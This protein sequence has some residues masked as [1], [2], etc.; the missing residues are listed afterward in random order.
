MLG[1]GIVPPVG[2]GYPFGG[3]SLL[4]SWG[5]SFNSQRSWA[6][7]F[8]AL[9]RSND[10]IRFSTSSSALALFHKTHRA[11]CR[12]FNGFISSEQLSPS[13]PPHG[14]GE[15]GG[16]CSL[17]FFDLSGFLQL[18]LQKKAS[19]SFLSPLA[20][21]LCSSHKKHPHEPQGMSTQSG[22]LFLLFRGRQ[23]VWPFP[24]TYC[25]TIFKA[26]PLAD[27]FFVFRIHVPLRKRSARS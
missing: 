1:I 11:L 8:E 20:L 5:V 10:R 26:K 23:P 6:S 7:L 16:R 17:E 14:L 21:R 24:P 25:P 3:F 27:Y 9:F 15:D 19:P 22:G 18:G 2:F 4:Q 12:R 13:M